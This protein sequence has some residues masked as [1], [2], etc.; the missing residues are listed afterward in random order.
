MFEA[1][2]QITVQKK[3][4]EKREQV[5][6]CHIHISDRGFIGFVTPSQRERMK[7]KHQLQTGV[8]YLAN[9]ICLC[10]HLSRVWL[11]CADVSVRFVG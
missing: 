6:N 1:K 10:A 8:S 7:K 3:N 2:S 11:F 5:T 4:G 9:F